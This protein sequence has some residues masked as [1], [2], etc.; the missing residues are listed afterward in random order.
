MQT[1]FWSE[2]ESE[3]RA[4]VEAQI[5]RAAWHRSLGLDAFADKIEADVQ[6]CVRLHKRG[7][8]AMALKMIREMRS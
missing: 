1:T 2:Y 8:P 7:C 6:A 5:A 4:A 3:M